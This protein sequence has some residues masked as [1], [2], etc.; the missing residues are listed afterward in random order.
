MLY[1]DLGVGFVLSMQRVYGLSVVGAQGYK[2]VSI[3][4]FLDWVRGTLWQ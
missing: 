4:R 3:M 2:R 1:D